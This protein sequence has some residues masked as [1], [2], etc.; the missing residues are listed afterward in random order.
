[1]GYPWLMSLRN[2]FKRPTGIAGWFL[3]LWG[4][5]GTWSRIEFLLGKARRLAPLMPVLLDVITSAWFRLALVVVGPSLNR[6]F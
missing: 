4:V 2:S 5:V 3:L 1:M 6:V